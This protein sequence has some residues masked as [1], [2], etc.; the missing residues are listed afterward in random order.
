VHV[1]TFPPTHTQ[2]VMS[3]IDTAVEKNQSSGKNPGEPSDANDSIYLFDNDVEPDLAEN[4]QPSQKIQLISHINDTIDLFGNDI[5]PDPAEKNQPSEKNPMIPL[6]S[7]T[8]LISLVT[9]LNDI[10][11]IWVPPSNE[12]NNAWEN[13][14]NQLNSWRNLKWKVDQLSH[15]TTFLDLNVS[16]QN[17]TITFSKYQK[18]LNLYLYLPPLSAHPPSC[19]KGLIKGQVQ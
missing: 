4:N 13:F 9:M 14:K 12:P 18:P 17:S 1:R 16:I 15:R 11:G 5:K 10:L 7:M 8:Q 3:P 19:L 2:Q 6:M